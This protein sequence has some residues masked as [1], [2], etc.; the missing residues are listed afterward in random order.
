[1]V[2]PRRE[3]QTAT[4]VISLRLTPDEFTAATAAAGA[5][6]LPLSAF[7][8]A[9]LVESSRS[10]LDPRRAVWAALQQE[11][12][13]GKRRVALP[14]LVE[15]LEA[16]GLPLA[17]IHAALLELEAEGR[18]ALVVD[19]IAAH[20]PRAHRALLVKTHDGR[21][22]VFFELTPALSPSRTGHGGGREESH[23]RSAAGGGKP[24]QGHVRPLAWRQAPSAHGRPGCPG[25]GAPSP[26]GPR[27]VPAPEGRGSAPDDGARDTAFVGGGKLHPAGW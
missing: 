11:A 27:N 1:M 25:Q 15:T 4:N 20:L 3:V 23:R 19:P 17:Q 10:E 21:M 22:A 13:G 14:H 7:A 12:A 26:R 6:G 5:R 18:G 9:V 2:R 24:R 16:R 8:R